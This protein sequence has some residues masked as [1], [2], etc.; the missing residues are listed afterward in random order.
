MAKTSTS[1][2]PGEVH[3]PNGRPPK[4]YSIT[5]WFQDMFTKNPDVKD[6]VGKAIL[7]KAEAGDPAAI[8]LVWNYMDHMPLQGVDVTSKGEQVFSGVDYIGEHISK[9][10]TTTA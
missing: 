7:A 5:E 2:K 3:N 9:T 6:R 1:F 4:G 8:K 10:D